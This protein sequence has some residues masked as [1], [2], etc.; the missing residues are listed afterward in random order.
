MLSGERNIKV[1]HPL[2]Q[3]LLDTNIVFVDTK[4]NITNNKVRNI[5]PEKFTVEERYPI[6]E[7]LKGA[8]GADLTRFALPVTVN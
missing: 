2:K 6:G 8:V 4:K 5:L 3:K 1:S 7:V